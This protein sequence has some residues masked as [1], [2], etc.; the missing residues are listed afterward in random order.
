LEQEQNRDKL[1]GVVGWTLHDLRR[2]FRTVHGRIGTPPHIAERSINHVNGIA[3][4]VEQTYNTWTYLP[5][6]RKAMAAYE[7][8]LVRIVGDDLSIP[9]AA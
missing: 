1:C 3:S 6:M 2:T 8:E 7:A 4:E 5:E 9:H